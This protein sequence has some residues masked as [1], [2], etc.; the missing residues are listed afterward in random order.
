LEII[1]WSKDDISPSVRSMIKSW[2]IVLTTLQLPLDHKFL[3]IRFILIL[4]S[5]QSQVSHLPKK[6]LPHH[7]P[8][9]MCILYCHC[10]ILYYHCPWTMKTCHFVKCHLLPTKLNHDIVHLLITHCMWKPTTRWWLW[11]QKNTCRYICWC[12]LVDYSSY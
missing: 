9:H 2:T 12:E 6:N 3:P 8:R 4:S 5:P 7:K 10:H 1:L 11:E